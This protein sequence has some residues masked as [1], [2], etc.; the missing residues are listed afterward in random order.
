M[1]QRFEPGL[2]VVQFLSTSCSTLT[3]NEDEVANCTVIALT[4][5]AAHHRN[6]ALN[7]TCVPQC[8]QV[9]WHAITQLRAICPD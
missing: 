3:P 8:T 5:Y 1:G 2:R 7:S 9:V 4:W 6:A